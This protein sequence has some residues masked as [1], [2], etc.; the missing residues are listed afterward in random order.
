MTARVG[1]GLFVALFVVLFAPCTGP[2]IDRWVGVGVQGQPGRWVGSVGLMSGV[3]LVWRWVPGLV[4]PWS[5]SGFPGRKVDLSM[6]G[7]DLGS[8][9]AAMGFYTRANLSTG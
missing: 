5:L 6:T 3:A 7:C 1:D 9:L 4:V 2:A 8:Q